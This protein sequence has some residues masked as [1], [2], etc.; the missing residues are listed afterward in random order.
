[1]IGPSQRAQGS[2]VPRTTPLHVGG[3]EAGP[4]HNV[5][6]CPALAGVGGA[7]GRG[8]T[9]WARVLAGS[10]MGKSAKAVP[11]TKRGTALEQY[12]AKR[13]PAKHEFVS[14]A[15]HV[16]QLRAMRQDK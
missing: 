13:S 9:K 15:I 3:G 14:L 11:T 6:Q 7:E 12:L 1:M 16:C 4:H 10:S 8:T 2:A 5:H